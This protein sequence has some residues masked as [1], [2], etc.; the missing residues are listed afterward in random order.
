MSNA[1]DTEARGCWGN[2]D[3][4]REHERKTKNYTKEKW[5]EANDGMKTIFAEFAAY[6]QSRARAGS[7]EAQTLVAKLQAHITPTTIPALTK[8]LQGLVRRML[9]MNASKII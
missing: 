4:F 6:K 7:A 2:T 3:A 1:Y 5:T 9:Q 8:F